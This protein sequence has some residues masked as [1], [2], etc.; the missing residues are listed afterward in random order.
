MT[1]KEAKQNLFSL[2]VSE[3]PTGKLNDNDAVLLLDLM[4]DEEIRSSIK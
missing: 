3:I 4:K 2:L 1:V